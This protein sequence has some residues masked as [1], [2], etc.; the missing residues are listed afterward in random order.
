M[1]KCLCKCLKA[2]AAV[3]SP[4]DFRYAVGKHRFT[5]KRSFAVP[6]IQSF[7]K[8][9]NFR[10]FYAL[11]VRCFARALDCERSAAVNRN[12]TSTENTHRIG[13]IRFDD[14][15]ARKLY[16]EVAVCI[17]S[18]RFRRGVNRM[19][20]DMRI[21]QR[22]L[23]GRHCRFRRK[24]DRT[25]KQCLGITLYGVFALHRYY[26]FGK[27]RIKRKSRRHKNLISRQIIHR[28]A[29]FFNRPSQKA[30]SAF[31]RANFWQNYLIVRFH[32]YGFIRMAVDSRFIKQ[33]K[34]RGVLHIAFCK[35]IDSRRLISALGAGFAI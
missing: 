6:Y 18:D 20:P 25:A 32:P 9:F 26:G 5:V 8:V 17:N 16:I 7:S 22:Q 14:T 11:V 13:D 12:R 31:Y 3:I 15:V 23:C 35:R 19:R 33:Q 4:I 34:N 30:V 1:R 29:A 21:V 28:F 10:R 24:A 27:Y 2:C